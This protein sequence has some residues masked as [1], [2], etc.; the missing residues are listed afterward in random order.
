MTMALREQ[1]GLL[2]GHWVIPLTRLLFSNRIKSFEL[3][4]T[5]RIRLPFLKTFS[6]SGIAY[7]RGVYVPFCS[8]YHEIM[9]LTKSL[10]FNSRIEWRV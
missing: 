4:C 6:F 7:V 10:L 2:V 1:D 3:H 9:K 8:F 5:L